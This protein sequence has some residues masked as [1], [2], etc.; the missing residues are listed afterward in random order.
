[1]QNNRCK[2][3]M[4]MKY[5]LIII[6]NMVNIKYAQFIKEIKIISLCTNKVYNNLLL[7]N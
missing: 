4:G 7:L 2:L 3:S 5:K 1:M 6:I